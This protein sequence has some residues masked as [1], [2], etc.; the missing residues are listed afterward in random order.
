MTP[1]TFWKILQVVWNAKEGSRGSHSKLA[2]P[3]QILMT[4]EYGREYRTLFHIGKDWGVQKSTV[5]RTVK[6]I[7]DSFI[8]SEEFRLLGKKELSQKSTEI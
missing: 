3:D 5:Q 8:S 6:R 4:L 7:E 1:E 2:I